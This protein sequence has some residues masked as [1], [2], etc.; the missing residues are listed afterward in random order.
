MF[1]K[2][3][4]PR[5]GTTSNAFVSSATARLVLRRVESCTM[6]QGTRRLRRKSALALAAR[7]TN[8]TKNTFADARDK[9]AMAIE[10]L[11]RTGEEKRALELLD[12]PKRRPCPGMY[13]CVKGNSPN[14]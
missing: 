5:G 11:K 8:W 6:S 13:T 1:T 2:M 9:C 7:T 10:K 14:K 12:A 3:L 4:E